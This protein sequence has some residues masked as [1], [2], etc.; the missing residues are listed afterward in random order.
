MPATG[1][2]RCT[3]VCSTPW[4]SRN[5]LEPAYVKCARVVGEVMKNFHPHGDSAIYDT[6]VRMAQDFTLRY[7]LIDGQGNFGS[8]DGDRRGDALHR[9]PAREDR[10]RAPRRHRQ[11]H[12]RLPPELRRPRRSRAVLPTRLPNLLVNGVSG[13]AVGMA[14]NIPPHNLNET[15]AGCLACSRTRDHGRRPDDIVPAPDFPT[16]GII[17]GREGVR[18]AYR[19]GR[20][21]VV[22]R[23]RTAHRGPRQGQPA[24]DR[25]RR[26]ALPGEQGEPARSASAN[27]SATRSSRAS[28]TCATS[29]TS[30][31]CAR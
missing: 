25:H 15:I 12:G 24:G 23:A 19:T 10:R 28:R 26:A 9:V 7:P 11:G 18:D 29:R 8:V 6:L 14:T 3:A 31:A 22:I 27:W 20:G 16:G 1:S 17:Y 30:P 5:R 13:I 21:R 2:S 4:R